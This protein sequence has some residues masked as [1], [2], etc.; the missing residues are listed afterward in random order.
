MNTL[1]SQ[2][3]TGFGRLVKPDPRDL[4]YLVKP[5]RLAA[6]LAK[7]ITVKHWMVG[8]V[9]D[10]GNTPQCVAYSGKQF[11]ATGPVKNALEKA[12][13]TPEQLYRQCQDVDEWPG[14]SYDGTSVRALFQVLQRIGFVSEYNWAFSNDV[15]ASW[16]LTQG[17]MVVGTDWLEGMQQTDEKGFIRATGA[18]VGG[19]AW[20]IKGTDTRKV[21]PDGSIGA[22]RMVNSWGPGWGERGY[23]W[24]SY[25]DFAKLLDRW[26]EAATA[27]ELRF[28]PTTMARSEAA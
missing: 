2:Q 3:S 17:P 4:K 22:H 18:P 23:A 8:K 5:P 21:C 11:L 7:E 26:G 24:I 19:H 27:K 25:A 20:L 12:G 13:F 16:V 28:K 9:L 14:S 10:Q 15:V 1:K 6:L